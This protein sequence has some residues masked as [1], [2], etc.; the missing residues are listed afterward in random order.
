MQKA[1]NKAKKQ[2]PAIL[3][4]PPAFEKIIPITC[5]TIPSTADLFKE[6]KKIFKS[7]MLTNA[8]Y[9]EAFEEAVQKYTGAK[10]AI[11]TN[12]C[13][14]GMMLTIKALGLKG[15]VILPSFTFHATA[16]AA[17]WNGLKLVFVDCDPKTYNIDPKKVEAAITPQT[18]AI[19][20]VYIFG[21]PP[22]IESLEKVAKKHKLKLILDAAHGFG[23]KYQGKSAGGFGDAESFSL[24]PTK[25]LTSG[26]GGLVTTNDPD[27]AR[28]LKTGRNYGDPGTYDSEFSGFNARMSE[29]HA[30][31][32]LTSLKVLTKNVQRRNQMVTLYKKLLSQIPGIDF[33]QIE[34]GNISSYKDFSILIDAKAFGLSRDQAYQALNKENIM[35]K[36]YFYPAVH[37][38]I[39][40]R[41]YPKRDTGL[42]NTN[43]IAENS[44][45]LPLFSHITEAQ[46]RKIVKTVEVLHVNANAIKKNLK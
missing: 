40:F 7:G 21:N 43:F 12:S 38:Q 42:K 22:D 11:A 29:L 45:S 37:N 20:A 5:P 41:G 17:A 30:A 34:K 44:L 39:A 25:L 26:E 24:S 28:K 10:Y 15:E 32:G 9:V 23:T 36:K 16:H 2:L 1:K 13:T 35:V 3:G 31:L 8:S 4:G 27:L 18:C 6:Y 19:M 33:Q 14:N 46:I